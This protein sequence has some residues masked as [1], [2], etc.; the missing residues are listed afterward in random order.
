ML[1]AKLVVM[2]GFCKGCRAA[3]ARLHIGKLAFKFK[4]QLC[5]EDASLVFDAMYVISILLL[6]PMLLATV[7]NVPYSLRYSRMKVQRRLDRVNDYPKSIITDQL[8]GCPKGT[9]T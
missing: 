6:V 3:T 2:T 9:P 5:N 7:R 8:H 4:P 1:W